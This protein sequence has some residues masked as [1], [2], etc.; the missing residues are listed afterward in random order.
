[1]STLSTEVGSKGRLLVVD[2]ELNVRLN[3][4][5]LLR[6]KGYQVDEASN[7]Q[8][9]LRLI[10][11]VPYDLMTLDMN[12]P[13]LTGPEVMPRVHELR[14]DLLIVVLTGNATVDNAIAAVKANA[15]DYVLKPY[16]SDDLVSTVERAMQEQAR[17]KQR[18]RVLAM[19]GQMMDTLR[20]T[21]ETPD[22][23]A[24]P[25][26]TTPSLPP[27]AD[28]VLQVG[29]LILDR[30][31]RLATIQGDEIRTVELTESEASILGALMEHPNQVLSPG[32]LATTA[33]GYGEMDKWTIESVVRS[34]VFRLR[35]KIE[36][37]AD[38]PHLICTVRGRG[39]FLAPV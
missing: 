2:D 26:A 11:S 9:A 36:L 29:S 34:S 32:Q 37:K 19:V 22:V 5:E 38:A 17:R 1:M 35:Q 25:A 33:L 13:G 20:P 28:K 18:Q 23:I 27:T 10:Q 8:E 39:Y 21:H 12:M 31:K 3:T 7:G 6:L 4:A 14:P 16:R 30:Q 15:F 24:A